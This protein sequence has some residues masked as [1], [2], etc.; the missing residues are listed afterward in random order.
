M[1]EWLWLFYHLEDEN[2]FCLALVTS[3]AFGGEICN[4]KNYFNV[5]QLF[6]IIFRDFPH[7]NSGIDSYLAIW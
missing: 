3:F 2:F 1:N 7:D 4:N 5:V 6:P